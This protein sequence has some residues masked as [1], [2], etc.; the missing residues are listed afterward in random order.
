[1]GSEKRTVSYALRAFFS[2]EPSSII[3][4]L[5]AGIVLPSV[6]M[7]N[8][9]D[10]PLTTETPQPPEVP[11]TPGALLGQLRIFVKEIEGNLPSIKPSLKERSCLELGIQDKHFTRTDYLGQKEDAARDTIT[12]ALRSFCH[13]MEI[14][15]GNR[16]NRQTRRV[17]EGYDPFLKTLSDSPINA[18]PGM[19]TQLVSVLE[20]IEKQDQE[21]RTPRP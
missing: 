9:F 13:T 14:Y 10:R 4:G 16:E 20:D 6:R 18:I 1:M 8:P 15:I 17:K 7:K 19:L 12:L 5:V 11:G 2:N 3:T 21:H